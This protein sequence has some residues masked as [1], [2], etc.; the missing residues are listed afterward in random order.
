MAI[1]LAAARVNAGLTAQQVAEKMNVS[2]QIVYAWEHG[3]IIPRWD[4]FMQLCAI[5]GMTPNDIF[6]PECTI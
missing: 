4:K 1:S 3:R 6:I 2:R 5:Y